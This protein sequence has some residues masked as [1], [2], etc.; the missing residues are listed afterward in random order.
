ME[1]RKERYFGI[2]KARQELLIM[3]TKL[4]WRTAVREGHAIYPAD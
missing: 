1:A 3:I 4:T 2:L